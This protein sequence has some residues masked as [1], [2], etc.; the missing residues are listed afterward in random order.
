[1]CPYYQDFI[2]IKETTQFCIEYLHLFLKQAL[3][4]HS[5]LAKTHYGQ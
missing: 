1:M 4:Q 5:L 2:P 3:I